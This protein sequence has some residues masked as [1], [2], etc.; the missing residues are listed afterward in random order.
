M[1]TIADDIR[2]AM[3]ELEKPADTVVETPA[4]ETAPEITPQSASEPAVEAVVS[5]DQSVQEAIEEIMEPLPVWPEEVKTR[6]TNLGKLSGGKTWQKFLIEREKERDADYTR[7]QQSRA[8]FI[9]TYEPIEQIIAPYREELKRANMTPANL[10]QRYINTELML[11]ENPREAIKMIAQTYGVDLNQPDPSADDPV[12]NHPAF[13]QLRQE[14][15]SL[16]GS[17][18]QRE[19]QEQQAQM[20]SRVHEIETFAEQRD[21]KGLTHPYFSD[22]MDDMVL[23]AQAERAAGRTPQLQELYD[24]AVWANPTT[25][26][27]ALA[28]QSAEQ[29]RK[30]VEEAAQKA[31]QARKASAGATGSPG[32]SAPRTDRS[33]REEIEHAFGG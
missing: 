29:E 12:L 8:D 26:Q 9:K 15:M 31:A 28:A 20:S 30:R 10:L 21:E 4:T 5:T 7:K 32:A 25:R 6:F 33:L 2:S 27:K 23:L 14:I 11:R 17:L 24:R 3:T 16:R 19:Q 22:V 18:T 13:S 1:S